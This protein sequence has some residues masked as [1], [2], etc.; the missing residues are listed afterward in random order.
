MN[1]SGNIDFNIQTKDKSGI[2]TSQDKGHSYHRLLCALFDVSVLKALEEQPFYH[3]VYHDG[4][5]EGL[6]N[7][8]KIRFLELISDVI[9]SGRIQYMLS[10]IDSDLPRD[11]ETEEKIKFSA[12]KTKLC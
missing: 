1:K 12:Q 3:F 11:I 8:V 9:Q 6:D 2:D 4:I 10:V 5:L 7:R